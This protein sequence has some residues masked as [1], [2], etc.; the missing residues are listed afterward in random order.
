M[1]FHNI[2]N[3]LAA[4]PYDANDNFLFVAQGSIYP[5]TGEDLEST[6]GVYDIGSAT[7]KFNDVYISGQ[8][9]Y[10]GTS[11]YSGSWQEMSRYVFSANTS[12]ISINVNSDNDKNYKLIHIFHGNTVS[13]IYANLYF[14]GFSVG[15][16]SVY[17]RGVN[18][19]FISPPND[20]GINDTDDEWI[21]L[22]DYYGVNEK[23]TD[24][25]VVDIYS[26]GQIKHYTKNSV[27]TTSFLTTTAV[28]T[29]NFTMGRIFVDTISTIKIEYSGS[30]SADNTGTVVVLY[31]TQ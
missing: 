23:F 4:I 24:L 12:S 21:K 6:T 8:L 29:N 3:S 18:N 25:S 2:I 9:N 19:G 16:G 27:Y 20:K 15:S 13:A 11:T 22:V 28:Y 10:S 31:R 14:N 30:A 17:G 7:K 5:R 26:F 1:P